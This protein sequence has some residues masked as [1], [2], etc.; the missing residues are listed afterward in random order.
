MDFVCTLVAGMSPVCGRHG[1][2]SSSARGYATVSLSLSFRLNSC[3][4]TK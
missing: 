4:M 2:L 1:V 3:E